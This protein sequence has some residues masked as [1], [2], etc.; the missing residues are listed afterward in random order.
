MVNLFEQW[1]DM[2][3][4][5]T[6]EPIDW[7]ALNDFANR[8]RQDAKDNADMLKEKMKEFDTIYEDP[9]SAKVAAKV[10]KLNEVRSQIQN[11]NLNDSPAMVS[12]QLS[13]YRNPLATDATNFN[14]YGKIRAKNVGDTGISDADLQI[15]DAGR[16]NGIE[17]NSPTYQAYA[18]YQT[19]LANA[20]QRLNDDKA[21]SSYNGNTKELAAITQSKVMTL[22]S[23][24]TSNLKEGKKDALDHRL[25]NIGRLGDK[26][27]WWNRYKDYIELDRNGKPVLNEYGSAIVKS[28]FT[29]DTRYISGAMYKTEVTPNGVTYS[30]DENGNRI[31]IDIGRGYDALV[32]QELYRDLMGLANEKQDAAS[33]RPTKGSGNDDP[34]LREGRI[35]WYQAA[36]NSAFR[37]G[38]DESTGSFIIPEMRAEDLLDTN[39]MSKEQ[40]AKYVEENK[41]RST[42]SALLENEKH[43]AS[44]LKD[45]DKTGGE[46]FELRKGYIDADYDNAGQLALPEKVTI[47]ELSAL[48]DFTP[49][50]RE[51]ETNRKMVGT[52]SSSSSRKGVIDVN[53][54]G[55]NASSGVVPYYSYVVSD[56][57]DIDVKSADKKAKKE[58]DGY[59]Y[60]SS[61]GVPIL[62]GDKNNS[63]TKQNERA[64]EFLDF[65]I[66]GGYFDRNLNKDGNELV[67]TQ[68]SFNGKMQTSADRTGHA[69]VLFT[70]TTTMT[71]SEFKKLKDAFFKAHPDGA[72]DHDN[73]IRRY[74]NV[75]HDGKGNVVIMYN[76]AVSADGLQM[77]QINNI[78]AKG[79]NTIGSSTEYSDTGNRNNA[80]GSGV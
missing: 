42:L 59:Y 39:G 69:P 41:D 75:H 62:V 56:G 16:S 9:N 8:A 65:A 38:F 77:D 57:C 15:M 23:G 58:T 47:D 6:Y 80:T 68:I 76:R 50:Q 30:K 78:S 73:A 67:R 40:R 34:S 1:N 61:S 29:G 17:D 72:S 18:D 79:R 13:R 71:N 52:F 60:I 22:A 25:A 19:N 10:A 51:S 5:S 2:D 49:V 21:A 33:A 7:K 26:S 64:K 54:F 31:R 3:F 66:G 32:N 27:E 28:D 35:T 44:E 74:L 70:F 63:M 11:I 36:S 20:K 24:D 48:F 46:A 43:K 55:D 37:S 4:A 12:A 14:N 53:Q 45:S